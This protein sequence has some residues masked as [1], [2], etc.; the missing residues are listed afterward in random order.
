[1]LKNK[2]VAQFWTQMNQEIDYPMVHDSKFKYGANVQKQYGK[3]VT[4]ESESTLK[5]HFLWGR[6]DEEIIK[7]HG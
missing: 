2:D 3:D 7:S 5:Y 6:E 1:M 4:E